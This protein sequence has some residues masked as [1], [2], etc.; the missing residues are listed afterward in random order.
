MP[1]AIGVAA[2]CFVLALAAALARM[3][4]W[5]VYLLAAA[6]F[7]A[8]GTGI[9]L[10]LARDGARERSALAAYAEIPLDDLLRATVSAEIPEKTRVLIVRVLNDRHPGWQIDLEQ[11]DADWGDLRHARGVPATCMKRC[12]G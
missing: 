11:A 5:L 7:P 9:A 4:D 1:I 10:S 12:C 8:I 2:L 3:P 6:S